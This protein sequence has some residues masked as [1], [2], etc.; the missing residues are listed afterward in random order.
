[1]LHPSTAGLLA[2]KG[3]DPDVERL[4]EGVAFLTARIRERVDDAVP[5]VVHGMMQLLLPHYLRTIPST[6]IIQYEPSIK[7]LRG[8]HTVADATG[9]YRRVWIGDATSTTVDELQ[10]KRTCKIG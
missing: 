1:M 6:S 10:K 9:C 7:S 5:E 2:E 3:S 4:L 8:V